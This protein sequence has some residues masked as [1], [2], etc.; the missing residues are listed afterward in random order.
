MTIYVKKLNDKL[1]PVLYLFRYCYINMQ[2]KTPL[3]I[4]K[5]SPIA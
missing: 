3:T 1:A 4:A 2:K 5:T